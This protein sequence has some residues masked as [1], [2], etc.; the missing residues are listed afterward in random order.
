MYFFTQSS[1]KD[2]SPF[3]QVATFF[4]DKFPAAFG[5]KATYY[6]VKNASSESAYIRIDVAVKVEYDFEGKEE[7]SQSFAP[8]QAAILDAFHKSSEAESAVCLLEL[9]LAQKGNIMKLPT[10][11]KQAE[12]TI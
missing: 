12:C 9:L 7:H 3:A 11:V 6:N 5:G 4:V 10:S 1:K 2:A 8:Y